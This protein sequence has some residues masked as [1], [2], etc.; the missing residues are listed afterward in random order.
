MRRTAILVAVFAIAGCTVVEEAERFADVESGVVVLEGPELA[1]ELASSP[2]REVS[3]PFVRL[4]FYFDADRPDAF[5]VATS[6]DGTEWSAWTTATV[7]HVEMEQTAG[8]VGTI[9]VGEKARF[10]K[11][12]SVAGATATFVRMEMLAFT[13]P[14]STET[15]DG[16][17]RDTAIARSIGGVEVHTRAEWG[18]RAPRCSSP[19][20]GTVTRMAIHHTETPTND[21][22]SPQA[23][24]RQIQSYHMDVKGWCDIG[25]HY[26]M[27]RDGQLWDGRPDSKLGA[28][29]GG[30]NTG[31]I[32]ISVMGTHDTTPLTDAQLASIAGL[33]KALADAHDLPIT[34]AKIKG[35]RE[36][37]STTCPGNTL[38]AQIPTI[39]E[40]AND[41][42][43]GGGGGGGGSTCSLPTDGPWACG[44]LTGKSTNAD[45]TYA[46]TSFGCWVDEDGDP[47]GDAGDNCIPACSL[48]SIGCS[49][50]SGP[51]C[52]RHH[53]WY[54]ADADRFGCGS[55]LKVTN[56]DNGKS[57]I[58]ITIDRGPNCTI[59]NSIDFWVLDMSYPASYYLFGGPTSA[60][61]RADVQVEV[62]DPTTPLG[63]TDGSPTCHADTGNNAGLQ[64]VIYHGTSSGN[65]IP[66]ATITLSTGE[67]TTA[68]GNGYYKIT[69]G[70]APGPVTI[71]ATASGYTTASVERTLTNGNVEWGSVKLEP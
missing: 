29:A 46:T 19:P 62:V 7:T 2:V 42:G 70:L 51:Q 23:R 27:S 10:Y 36:Y 43:G 18:A 24:L 1:G 20:L 12:R 3:E 15:D 56:L 54:V 34:A 14:E 39:L 8:F 68:D 66:N 26:L 31:N 64:G 22:M 32:G 60:G 52:E 53:N 49:G 44:G 21:T 67:T 48:S 28:H 25:Y 6:A 40:L 16:G 4:G 58:L 57:A 55:R 71:T 47:H 45:G 59:E 11:L 30:A 38:F 9:D 17:D 5:E 37:T 69:T 35:H 41:M 65:R 13:L 63:P 33:V 61:E 50:M